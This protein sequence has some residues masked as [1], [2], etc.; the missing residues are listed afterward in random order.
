MLSALTYLLA[1]IL[2]YHASMGTEIDADIIR[3]GTGLVR[4]ARSEWKGGL[5]M[6]K[7]SGGT[8]WQSC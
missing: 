5:T 1:P 6:K 4:V 2:D 8:A 3:Y 7:V